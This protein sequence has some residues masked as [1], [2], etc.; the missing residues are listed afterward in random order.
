MLALDF[1]TMCGEAVDVDADAD[2]E[3]GAPTLR[4]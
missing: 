1:E 3:D 2:V 4:F